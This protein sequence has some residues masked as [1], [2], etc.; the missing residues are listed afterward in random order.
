MNIIPG[1]LESSLESFVESYTAVSVVTRHFQIDI[2]DGVL[3]GNT[4]ITTHEAIEQLLLN[5]KA[6]HSF[7]FHL[8]MDDPK[9][10][11]DELESCDLSITRIFLHKKPFSQCSSRRSI[12][13]GLVIN[14]EDE[15]SV[16]QISDFSIPNLQIMTIHPG[17]QGTLFLPEQLN[18][19]TQLRKNGFKGSITLDGGIHEREAK[20]ITQLSD[21]PDN[22]IVG[23]FLKDDTENRYKKLKELLSSS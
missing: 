7:E 6:G 16:L 2:A 3:V 13:I 18:K 10:A 19:I 22:I 4:T 15:I 21:K 23:S 17:K 9:D 12:P 11:I 1:I 14:P 8:M 5:S 20:L